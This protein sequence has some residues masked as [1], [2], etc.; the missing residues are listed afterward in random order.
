MDGLGATRAVTDDRDDSRWVERCCH[1]V[2]HRRRRA[3]SRNR[4]LI[5]HQFAVDPHNPAAVPATMLDRNT[6]T[7]IGTVAIYAVGGVLALGVGLYV[8]RKVMEALFRRG[9]APRK[10]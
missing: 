8:A 10:N 7:L 6:L 4:L 5:E 9:D 2:R 3:G 1:H